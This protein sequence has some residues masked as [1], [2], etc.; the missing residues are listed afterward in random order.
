MEIIISRKDVY[1]ETK[2]YP[3]CEK[4]KL[5][6]AIAGTK[7]LTRPVLNKIKDLGYTVAFAPVE[8]VI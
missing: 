2:Y 7:T 6:A 1:G 4:A 8:E 3:V 5:F